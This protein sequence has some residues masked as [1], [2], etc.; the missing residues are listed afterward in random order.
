MSGHPISRR[1]FLKRTFAFSASAT[2]AAQVGCGWNVI[3][4]GYQEQFSSP[5][6]ANMLIV[7]DWGFNGDMEA[8]TSVAKAMESFVQRHTI[9]PDA[10]LMLGDNFYGAMHGGATSRRWKTQFEDMYPESTFNC[11]ANAVLG[12]H[13]Y[14]Y[15][16]G[17]KSDYELEYAAMG[18]TRFTLPNNWYRFT[19][20]AKDPVMTVIA[21][22][23][24]APGLPTEGPSYITMT[25]AMWSQQLAWL[26]SELQKP[27][28]TPFL[29]VMAH[30]PVYSNGSRGDNPVL[31]RDWSPLFHKYKVNLY[32]AGHDHDMQHLE[33]EGHPTSFFLSGGGGAPLAALNIHQTERGPFAQEVFGFSH[34]HCTADLMT[35]RHLDRSG[36]LIHKFTKDTTG[37]VTMMYSAS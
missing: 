24:N 25:D 19:V 10:M 30:H 9:S 22:D 2:L 37:N 29:A 20:P 36:S 17:L 12:N 15:A 27:L 32:M 14:Q 4:P 33:L 34:L 3:A 8:Q 18:N 1:R 13:D 16:P 6:P 23:S 31:I 21:L 26:E 28:E 5:N 7:G 11:P 35:L